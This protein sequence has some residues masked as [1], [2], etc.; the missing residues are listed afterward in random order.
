MNCPTCNQ[1]VLDATQ[2]CPHCRTT[3]MLPPSP[4]K[5]Q[6]M[7]LTGEMVE[8]DTSPG[9][10]PYAPPA[11]D[12]QDPGLNNPGGLGRVGQGP[13]APVVLPPLAYEHPP[14]TQEAKTTWGV[15]AALGIAAALV[16]GGIY[17]YSRLQSHNRI[18]N[19]ATKTRM[20]QAGDRWDYKM[21]ASLTAAKSVINGEIKGSSAMTLEKTVGNSRT[22]LTRSHR[23]HLSTSRKQDFT[24]KLFLSQPKSDGLLYKV[25]ETSDSDKTRMTSQ[26]PVF[27]P[28]KWQSGL[29]FNTETTYDDG[30]TERGDWKILGTEIV[31][32]PAGRFAT[33]KVNE[34]VDMTGNASNPLGDTTQHGIYWYAPQLGSFVK[35]EVKQTMLGGIVLTMNFLLQKT[36]V[37]DYDIVPA[38]SV[39]P[40]IKADK[41]DD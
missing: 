18:H 25:G 16:F 8:M 39:K 21:T 23:I 38:N 2:P 3:A 17:T 6:R 10:S 15:F 28:G 13:M 29:Q 14:M 24:E 7:A 4:Q 40:T 35:A 30:A 5:T 41:P 27:L 31:D 22:P 34:Q 19:L 33:W 9:Y 12:A 1:P 20:L 37:P 36:T 26:P 32:T 11:A